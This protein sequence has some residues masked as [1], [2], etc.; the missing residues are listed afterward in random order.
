MEAGVCSSRSSYD[1]S[2][3]HAGPGET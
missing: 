2:A 1:L 3:L